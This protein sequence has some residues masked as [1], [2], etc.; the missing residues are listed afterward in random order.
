MRKIRGCDFRHISHSKNTFP[1]NR[2]ILMSL[3]YHNSLKKEKKI[4]KCEKD[5]LEGYDSFPHFPY[6]QRSHFSDE[7]TNNLYI[8]NKYKLAIINIEK[9]IKMEEKIIRT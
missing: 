8:L 7:S 4:R 2:G 5:I 3:N 1:T 9:R 6:F